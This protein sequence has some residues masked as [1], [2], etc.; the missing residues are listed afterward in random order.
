MASISDLGNGYGLIYQVDLLG[1]IVSIDK[2][3][4]MGIRAMRQLAVVDAPLSA[5]RSSYGCFEIVSC[6]SVGTVD[7]ITVDGNDILGTPYSIGSSNATTEAIAIATQIN[8]YTPS[9]GYRYFAFNVGGKIYIQSPLNVGAATN[10]LVVDADVSDVSIVYEVANMANGATATAVYDALTGRNYYLNADYD[11]NGVTNTLEAPTDS[12]TNA[13]DITQYLITR[14]L[15][16]G[17]ATSTLYVN[18][19]GGISPNRITAIHKCKVNPD[20]L[21]KLVYIQPNTFIDGDILILVGDG[22]VTVESTPVTTSTSYL[23]N[24]YLINDAPYLLADN[25]T[26]LMLQYGYDETKGG[27][28]FIEITRNEVDCKFVSLT[29]TELNALIADSALTACTVYKIT[30]LQLI[31]RANTT[32]SVENSATY[33]ADYTATGKIGGYHNELVEI[34]N[35]LG[36]TYR[37]D[38]HRNRVGIT[39]LFLFGYSNVTDNLIFVSSFAFNSF[40]G[41]K[42]TINFTNNDCKNSI[43]NFNSS[44]PIVYSCLVTSSTITLATP[45]LFNC[46]I[47]NATV[48]FNAGTISSCIFDNIPALM[49]FTLADNFTSCIF[50]NIINK[51]YGWGGN[52]SYVNKVW[53]DKKNTFNHSFALTSGNYIDMLANEVFGYLQITDT[54]LSTN[55]DGILSQVSTTLANSTLLAYHNVRVYPAAGKTVTINDYSIATATLKNILLTVA[56]G[57]SITLVGN[58]GDWAEFEFNTTDY[59]WRL[60]DYFKGL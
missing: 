7:S 43:F 45:I 6:A 12:L 18:S 53:I 34:N 25:S 33:I 57:T 59:K 11:S 50:E 58:K 9:G 54:S 29:S 52:V 37:Y 14:G 32:E 48:R 22:S 56:S 41:D 40:I 31:V 36:I 19:K 39:G 28:I 44:D 3:N 26:I 2:N 51:G 38:V 23:K 10:G 60:V 30:D 1:N 4:E 24:I 49:Q 47:N 46:V 42:A 13:I 17:I 21:N 16:V 20:D 27:G 35:T 15:Q 5:D 55:I 8:S